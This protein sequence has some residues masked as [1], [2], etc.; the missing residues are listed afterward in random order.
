M[1]HK[2]TVAEKLS[3]VLPQ[4]DIETIYSLLEKPKSSEMGDVAF[5]AF[6]L[7][8]VERKA[9][10][11]IATDIVEKLDT[12][13]FEK[14][15]ATGPYVN[16]FLDKDAISHQVLTDVIA[17]K[18]QY[19]QLNIGQ[20]RNVTIDM[21]SPNI[22]K[23]FSVGHLRST[24]IGD[25]LANIHAKLGFNPIRINHLGDWG[26][27]FGMLIVAYKLWGD[28]VKKM[29]QTQFQNSSNSTFVSTLRPKKNLNWMR[30][31]ANGSKNWK[32][33]TK[34]PWNCGNGSVMKVWSNL[35]VS[36]KN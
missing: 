16:F 28:K 19:G 6:S 12:T 25:A 30:K 22:A 11:A 31:H 4:L 2:Q 15:V 27:Q 13:G 1:D 14:V 36:M 18:D 23:P 9:P 26:K 33:A 24:V 21:S 20:G 3:A 10:Q 29:K 5:P 17:E 8:K 32:M 7:A 34:K 35:T